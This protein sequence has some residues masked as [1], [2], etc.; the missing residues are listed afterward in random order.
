MDRVLTYNA[1]A[2]DAVLGSI[3]VQVTLTGVTFA[4]WRLRCAI[5]LLRL[6]R[7]V[8]GCQSV[9]VNLERSRRG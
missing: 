1:D 6:V 7:L 3:V 4:L 2:K 9:E 5:T 8:A